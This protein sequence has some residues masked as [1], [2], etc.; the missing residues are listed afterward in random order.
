MN[1]TPY[2]KIKV[3][4]LCGVCKEEA[5]ARCRRCGRP[6]CPAHQHRNEERCEACEEA[7]NAYPESP[8]IRTLPGAYGILSLLTLAV[9]FMAP[10]VPQSLQA[11]HAGGLFILIGLFIVLLLVLPLGLCS[12]DYLRRRFFLVRRK[13]GG[14]PL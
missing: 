13:P 4:S 3:R 6:L 9:V 1:T 14:W 12:F 7:F 10:C 11:I 8:A 5:T 2:R